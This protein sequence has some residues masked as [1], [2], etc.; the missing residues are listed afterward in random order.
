MRNNTK[1]NDVSHSCSELCCL[2]QTLRSHFAIVL[3]EY[4]LDTFIL[5]CYMSVGLCLNTAV[6]NLKNVF[7]I[8]EIGIIGISAQLSR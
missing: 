2:T 5:I 6:F 4:E 3:W 8:P 7:E 1:R